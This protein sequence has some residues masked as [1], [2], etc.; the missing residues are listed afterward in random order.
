MDNSLYNHTVDY[1]KRLFRDINT[2]LLRKFSKLFKKEDSGTRNRE[3]KDMSDERIRDLWNGCKALM[4]SII[5]T[6]FKYIK[7]PKA[8]MASAV[9]KLSIK[10]SNYIIGEELSL[11]RS[12]TSLGSGI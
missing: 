6:E 12:G 2:N 1:V 7:I 10:P 5:S 4:D 9:R 8:P 11:S 3:W